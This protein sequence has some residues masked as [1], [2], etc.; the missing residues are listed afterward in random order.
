MPW[1]FLRMEEHFELIKA[2]FIRCDECNENFF[3]DFLRHP[4]YFVAHFKACHL[5]NLLY[6]F[7][8]HSEEENQ[9]I[10]FGPRR[11]RDA[12]AWFGQLKSTEK[13]MI[14]MQDNKWSEIT[15][16]ECWSC[17]LCNDGK[18]DLTH[19][20]EL[21]ELGRGQAFLHL[22]QFHESAYEAF[23]RS[24]PDV[25]S[26]AVVN[27][28]SSD[29]P[30]GSS[31]HSSSTHSTASTSQ[32]APNRSTQ[33]RMAEAERSRQRRLNA[34]DEERR[35]EAMRSK[36]RRENLTP[37]QRQ[38][39]YERRRRKKKR[40]EESERSRKRREEASD[41]TKQKELLRSRE[42]R[43]NATEEQRQREALR[44][45]MR[46]QNATEEQKLKE[47]ERCRKR[48]EAKKTAK[49]QHGEG[50]AEDG[51][52]MEDHDP[53][54][55]AARLEYYGTNQVTDD[56]ES[57]YFTD[58]SVESTT[59]RGNAMHDAV[60]QSPSTSQA[61][62]LPPPQ[63]NTSSA[64][65]TAQLLAPPPSFLAMMQRPGPVSESSV[66]SGRPSE[67]SDGQQQQNG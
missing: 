48:Y 54:H 52:D 2:N 14:S 21:N 24:L 7:N 4:R 39:D 20:F 41:E 62:R 10:R 50:G 47:R 25:Q 19:V 3:F 56:G 67:E 28:R 34:T 45:R 46:R 31:S 64:F 60:N 65:F 36:R 61:F 6:R 55:G 66:S 11:K 49:H 40:L 57:E 26:S 1:R 8:G 59:R 32:V 18:A 58:R 51:E 23:L 42:R 37:V 13:R 15:E 27:L 5:K 44:S 30:G 35:L 29:L 33:Q 53:G 43:R 16:S 63:S 38:A 9:K 22:R 17:R 12:N